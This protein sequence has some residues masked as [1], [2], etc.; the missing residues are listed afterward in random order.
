MNKQLSFKMPV[1]DEEETKNE[2]EKVF[3]EYRMYL[4]QM[5]SD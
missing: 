4:S 2:V 5:P 1:L 3:E